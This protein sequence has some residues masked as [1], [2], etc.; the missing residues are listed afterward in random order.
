M[1]RSVP[2]PAFPFRMPA[3][4][5]KL[6]ALQ[7]QVTAKVHWDT[8]DTEVA[9]WLQAKHGLADEQ[10]TQMLRTAHKKR[11][12]AIRERALYLMIGSGIGIV[13]FG[14]HVWFEVQEGKPPLHLRSVEHILLGTSV[15]AFFRGLGRFVS[16]KTNATI[17]P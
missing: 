4:A 11:R 8:P 15:L 12:M 10:I 1:N 3:T 14:L 17:D 13:I 5:E 16:G 6:Q 2:N 9:E 7:D